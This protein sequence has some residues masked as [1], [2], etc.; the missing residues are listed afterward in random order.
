MLIN[1]VQNYA[2]KSVKTHPPPISYVLLRK[3]KIFCTF[4]VGQAHCVLTGHIL[5]AF[6]LNPSIENRQSLK[7]RISSQKTFMLVA[8]PL[9][10]TRGIDIR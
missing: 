5:K 7:R 8:Y 9:P 2:K 10:T 3:Y 6:L 1:H 4:A